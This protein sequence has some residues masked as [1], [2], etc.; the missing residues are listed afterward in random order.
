MAP[1]AYLDRALDLLEVLSWGM[2]REPDSFPLGGL[3]E[4]ARSLTAGQPPDGPGTA[5]TGS[6]PAAR[7]LVPAAGAAGHGAGCP[8]RPGAFQGFEDE[9]AAVLLGAA[10]LAEAACVDL[11]AAIARKVTAIQSAARGG[12]R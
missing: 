7:V 2:C 5:D 3:R 9:V 6:V 12:A 1:L 4:I 11:E 8:R 10:V